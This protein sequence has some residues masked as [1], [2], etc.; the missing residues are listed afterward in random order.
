MTMHKLVFLWAFGFVVSS[1]SVAA[2]EKGDAVKDDT[3]MNDN[4]NALAD[5]N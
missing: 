3:V 2:Q 1:I 5:D 4:Y